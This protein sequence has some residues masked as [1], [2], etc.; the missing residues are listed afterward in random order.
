M[1]Y[2]IGIYINEEYQNKKIGSLLLKYVLQHEKILKI[3]EIYLSVDKNNLSA[4]K[5]YE[6][7]NFKII[8]EEDLY[9]IMKKLN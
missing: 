7:N 2:W 6:K 5:L 4:I 9:F 8:E 3:N 1:K